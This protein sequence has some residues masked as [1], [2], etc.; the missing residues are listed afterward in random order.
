MSIDNS[1]LIKQTQLEA[2]T[3]FANKKRRKPIPKPESKEAYILTAVLS[4][5]AKQNNTFK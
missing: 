3:R 1:S 5:R 4:E 2:K